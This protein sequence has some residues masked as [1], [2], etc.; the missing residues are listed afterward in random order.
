MTEKERIWLNEYLKC[1]NA[2]EAARRA[3]YKSPEKQGW[4]KK[5]KFAD[6]IKKRVNDIA[7]SAEERLITL[8]EIARGAEKDSDRLA[9]VT[10][11]GKLAGDYTK[12][13]DHTTDGDKLKINVSLSNARD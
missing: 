4:Q 8:S 12:H 3:G 5:E 13:I 7:M 2:T 9:A 1:W 10:L 11:L 6:E